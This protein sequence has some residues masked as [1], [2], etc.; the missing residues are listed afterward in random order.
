MSSIKII[1]ILYQTKYDFS[2]VT[3][4]NEWR[5]IKHKRTNDFHLISNG[6]FHLN[7]INFII[8]YIKKVFFKE[9]N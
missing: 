4:K 9:F 3:V 7:E 2:N 8:K 6:C 5:H 1:K